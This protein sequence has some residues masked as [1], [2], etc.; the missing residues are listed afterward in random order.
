ML[1]RDTQMEA[2]SLLNSHYADVLHRLWLPQLIE[3]RKFLLSAK[4][5]VYKG[6]KMQDADPKILE[7]K[8]LF[9]LHLWSGWSGVG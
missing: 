3:P 5:V 2:G 6:G 8:L 4:T 1:R 7:K 9:T